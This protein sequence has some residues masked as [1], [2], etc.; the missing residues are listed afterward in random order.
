MAEELPQSLRLLLRAEAMKRNTNCET[1]L[2]EILAGGNPL[3]PH[4]SDL[5]RE[6]VLKVRFRGVVAE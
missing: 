4:L 5:I 6:L 2:S 1:L 3:P